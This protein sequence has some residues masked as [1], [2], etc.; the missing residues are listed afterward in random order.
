MRGIR[1]GGGSRCC[2]RRRGARRD[3]RDQR[4][5][6]WSTPRCGCAGCAHCPAIA[7]GSPNYGGRGGWAATSWCMA[8]CSQE[9]RACAA[10]CFPITNACHGRRGLRTPRWQSSSACGGCMGAERDGWTCTCWPGCWCDV[11]SCGPRIR[12]SP[13]WPRSWGSGIRFSV[14]GEG[15]GSV[16]AGGGAG[17]PLLEEGAALGGQAAGGEGERAGGAGK[18]VG[19]GEAELVEARG[20][21]VGDAG[22]EDDAVE[23]G[24]MAGG[25]A[26]RAGFAG[27]VEGAA[28]EGNTGADAR[29]G[30]DG[31]DFGVGGG[32]AGRPDLVVGLGD[33]RAGG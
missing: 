17:L 15:G 22:A 19:G 18:Q 11:G 25:Q 29:G 31:I 33:Q 2:S 28:G 27:G 24:P 4:W 5:W 20:A 6:Y 10:R 14:A 26:H 32:I 30:A 12:Y 16:G 7:R 13:G 1:R 8:S 3:E 23:A 9:I 21:G